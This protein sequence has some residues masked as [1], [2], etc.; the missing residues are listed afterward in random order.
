MLATTIERYCVAEGAQSVTSP[1]VITLNMPFKVNQ[2]ER[3][4][5]VMDVDIRPGRRIMIAT[6]TGMSITKYRLS[7]IEGSI[8]VRWRSLSS[9]LTTIRSFMYLGLRWRLLPTT[10][11]M[12][13]IR[14]N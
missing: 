11:G 8:G 1:V 2:T 9:G 12:K 10:E 5:Q 4:A 6:A 14:I 3:L 13:Q 7:S